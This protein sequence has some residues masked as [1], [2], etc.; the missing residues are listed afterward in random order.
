MKHLFLVIVII[1]CLLKA[2]G[3]NTSSTN[4]NNKLSL[5]LKVIKAWPSISGGTLSDNGDYLFYYISNQP[6]GTTTL[7]A[8]STN[9]TW[10]KAFRFCS[11]AV[12]TPDNKYLIYRSG[13]D[14]LNLLTLGTD[15]VSY[16]GSASS[17]KIMGD[18]KETWLAFLHKANGGD[19]NLLNLTS[20]AMFETHSVK[21]CFFSS[22]NKSILI[23]MDTLK[24]GEPIHVLKWVHLPDLQIQEIWSSRDQ[25]TANYSFDANREQVVFLTSKT[26]GEYNLWYFKLGM[27]SSICLLNSDNSKGNFKLLNQV[28]LFNND[29]TRIIFG[30]VKKENDTESSKMAAVEVWNYRDDELQSVQLEE[31]R[32]SR[33]Y[34]SI[35][36]LADK[37]IVRLENE[38]ILSI[39]DEYALIIHELGKRGISEAYWNSEAQLSFYLISLKDGKRILLRDKVTSYD[40]GIR[41]SPN[42]N[43]AVYYDFAINCFFSID[44][45][46]LSRKNI[47]KDCPTNW[48]KT[49]NAYP[50][51]TLAGWVIWINQ[52]RDLLISDN[53]DLW[54]IDPAGVRAPENLTNG[55]GKRQHIKFEILNEGEIIGGNSN[56]LLKGFN[57]DTKQYGF[58]HKTIGA[59]GDPEL[60]SIGPYVYGWWSGYG[61]V[62]FPPEKAKDTGVYLVVRMKSDEA[63]NYFTTKNFKTF[64]QVSDLQPQKLFKWYTTELITWKSERGYPLQGILYKPQ[65]FDSS[66]KYPV[67]FDYYE[68]RSDELNLYITPKPSEGRINIPMFVSNGYVVFVPDIHYRSAGPGIS[69]YESITSAANQLSKFKWVDFKKMGLQGHSFGGYETNFIITKT[70]LFAAACSASGFCD[71]MSAYN[72]AARGGYPMYSAEKGQVRLGGTP[73]QWP[74][75]YLNNSPILRADKIATPLLLMNNRNDYVV[76]FSQGLE[77][78][79]ALRRLQ[80]KVWMLQYDQGGHEL[81]NIDAEDFHTRMLQ[82]FDHFLKGK[83]APVWMTKGIRASKKLI[84][85]GLELDEQGQEQKPR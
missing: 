32:K 31:R 43:W 81:Q 41:I 62:N 66:K 35:L 26:T 80:K 2:Y 38:R 6:P 61:S 18:K 24:N 29:G 59:K 17:F 11:G 20:G 21:D 85:S 49:E 16:M 50:L 1:N 27:D 83:P 25:I 68:R 37:N 72:S 19:F 75:L 70:N 28:P 63:P 52:G 48:I 47:S 42:W 65:D 74:D 9:T 67:I 10:E 69:A 78:F 77:F 76:P 54:K 15:K 45:K 44:L 13:I 39:G 30:Q 5:D 40:G 33:T 82:F 60:L 8:K 14:S 23:T 7:I 56:L 36:S 64:T 34:T 53:Y 46:T 58:Y 22:N 79:V 73:W 4:F 84:E 57:K 3:Q 12:F 55:C 71:L 51:P